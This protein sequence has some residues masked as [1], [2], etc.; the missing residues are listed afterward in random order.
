MKIEV[1]QLKRGLLYCPFEEFR[2]V[3]LSLR[4]PTAL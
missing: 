4:T 1:L 3:R 2:Y